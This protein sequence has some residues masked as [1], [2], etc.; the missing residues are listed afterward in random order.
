MAIPGSKRQDV[1][2]GGPD[3]IIYKQG[4]GLQS[5]AA[6]SYQKVFHVIHATEYFGDCG[7]DLAHGKEITEIDF[8]VRAESSSWE[9]AIYSG[10]AEPYPQATPSFETGTVAA[11]E[12]VI[13]EDGFD[14][15][16]QPQWTH[17]YPTVQLPGQGFQVEIVAALPE[18][19]FEYAG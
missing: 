14:Y 15:T 3:G 2:F 17:R 13:S 11:S 5:D 8:F 18:D 19:D 10:D 4:I 7:G 6:D 1:F 9:G 16:M 12:L